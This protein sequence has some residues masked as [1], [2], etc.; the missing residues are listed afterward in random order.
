MKI[1][2]INSFNYIKTNNTNKNNALF[3]GSVKNAIKSNETSLLHKTLILSEGKNLQKKSN[4]NKTIAGDITAQSQLIKHASRIVLSDSKRIQATAK[5]IQQQ[6]ILSQI[7]PKDGKIYAFIGNNKEKTRDLF[8]FNSIS[9]ELE[10][11]C[12]NAK[13]ENNT[14]IADRRFVF[15]NG[16][17]DTYDESFLSIETPDSKYEKS[18]YRF[19]FENDELCEYSQDREA[20]QG[21]RLK[22]G[23]V[24]AFK[25]DKLHYYCKDLTY[26]Y[27]DGYDYA[28]VQIDFD[29]NEQ[30]KEFIEGEIQEPTGDKVYKK[31]FFYQNGILR[32]VQ[33]APEEIKGYSIQSEKTFIFQ[34]EKL[35]ACNI[36]E[37]QKGLDVT[38]SKRLEF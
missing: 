35:K 17:L 2:S 21:L 36:A 5:K 30:M 4:K 16:K 7:P 37:T 15:E 38:Y 26:Q 20:W 3:F 29:E 34:N 1:N 33:I 6:G 23:D 22:L 28:K 8:V 11:F 32:K 14:L 19:I 12:T 13:L 10:S 25:N 27:E 18:F 24:F 9:K 31:R